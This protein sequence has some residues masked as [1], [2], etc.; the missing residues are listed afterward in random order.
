MLS[1][2]FKPP[3][4]GRAWGSSRL[5]INGCCL[6]YLV[7]GIK[8]LSIYFLWNADLLMGIVLAPYICRVKAGEYS[9]R[10]FLPSTIFSVIALVFPV[11]TTLFVALLFAVLL[12]F[13][14]FKGKVSLVLF[15][16][17]LL[18]SPLFMYLSNAISFPI[19]I[20]LSEVVAG[21][22]S[23][24]GIAAHASGNIIELNGR[25]FSVD[26]A[27]AGLHML[28]MSFII[29]L[30]IIAHCQRQK[31]NQLGFIKIVLLLALTF[32]LNIAVNLC[33]IMLLVLFKIPAA[34]IFH[35]V[36]G[37][38]CLLVYVVLPL[39]WL[40]NFYLKKSAK[41]E[42]HPRQDQLIRLVPD[43]VRYP[44]IHLLFAG[45]L[46][47]ISCNLKSMDVLSNKGAYAV[48]LSGYKK[49]LLESGVIK[50][51]KPGQLVYLK[52]TP[53]YG[54]EH[55]PMICWQ[56]SGYN[57]T[58]IRKQTIAGREVYS[59][60]LTKGAD[61]IYSAWWFDNGRLKTV[62]QLEW[63]WAAAQ[64]SKPFYLVNVNATSEAGLLE[65]VTG[66]PGI[67]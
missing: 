7:I 24:V 23:R 37:V 48:T 41:V 26:Q 8:L 58:S 22:L 34:S 30:F 56:G 31:V 6:V 51:D 39:L 5:L 35:D 61:K 12:F 25:E 3:F 4:A 29:C 18:V 52:P 55:N 21:I 38:I 19:R 46:I 40:S 11:K 14:N 32:L 49:Q 33:R 15:F 63:R 54:P 50:F 42:R 67:K 65:A 28:S 36:T 60:I 43:E 62:S 59:G 13:E 64:D 16:L 45:A 1:R 10:Y 17:L 66:L 57:F 53:F 27:C 44:F 2:I 9:M 20:W 47:V